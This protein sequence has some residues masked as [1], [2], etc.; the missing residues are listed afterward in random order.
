MKIT[1]ERYEKGH[2][3]SAAS[4]KT[5]M[6]KTALDLRKISIPGFENLDIGDPHRL[7]SHSPAR[8]PVRCVST[9][10][11]EDEPQSTQTIEAAA[12]D[13]DRMEV[14]SFGASGFRRSKVRVL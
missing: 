14:Q 2:A 13:R 8:N 6:G 4:A 9:P 3:P 11:I 7:G 5:E 1:V 12:Q 10:S